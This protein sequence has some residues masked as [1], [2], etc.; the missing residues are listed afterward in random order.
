MNGYID[1]EPTYIERLRMTRTI[2]PG[3]TSAAEIGIT[4]ALFNRITCNYKGHMKTGQREA[5]L[6]FL[7]AFDERQ[8]K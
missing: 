7:R 3:K 8:P 1:L 4:Y 6:S 2:Q 5:I